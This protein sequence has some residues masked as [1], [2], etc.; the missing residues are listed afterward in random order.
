[1]DEALAAAAEDSGVARAPIALRLSTMGLIAPSLCACCMS[2]ASQP[3]RVAEPS[4]AS[5]LVHYCDA[6][7]AHA[8]SARTEQLAVAFASLLAGLAAAFAL[9]IAWGSFAVFGQALVAIVAST[10]PW[11][12]LLPRKP[13]PGHAA[14]GVAAWLAAGE[15]VCK[16]PRFAA[17]LARDHGLSTRELP[18]ARPP[19]SRWLLVPV[20]LSGLASPLCV[21]LLGCQVRVLNRTEGP[22]AVLVDGRLRGTV[23]PSS[24]ESPFAGLELELVSGQRRLSLVARDG[25][26]LADVTAGLRPG[27]DH[28][29]AVS[30]P[31]ADPPCFWLERTD[32]GRLAKEGARASARE[33]LSGQ[34]PLWALPRAVDSWFAPNPPSQ[35]GDARSSGGQRFALRQGRCPVGMG[36]SPII[37]PRP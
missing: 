28:L 24:A 19:L 29:F 30:D 15:L 14:R 12:A 17:L 34:G 26:V 5:V 25:R 18:K 36:E 11:L 2:T 23:A 13:K 31:A 22:A 21:R 35:G 6:C 20:L 3:V 7:H 16:N 27:V 1:M 8:S 4:G 33:Y 9:L 37:L 32:Y 10:L